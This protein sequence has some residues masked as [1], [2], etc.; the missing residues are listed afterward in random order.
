[1]AHVS[2]I[3]GLATLAE[4]EAL[5]DIESLSL[6]R[7]DTFE[8][9]NRRKPCQKVPCAKLVKRGWVEKCDGS[10]RLTTEGQQLLAVLRKVLAPDGI[11]YTATGQQKIDVII[12]RQLLKLSNHRA[13][14]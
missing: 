2:R 9:F 14:R 7:A 6:G 12:A 13:T 10:Y 11:V 4:I 5:V 8:G 3:A 1:M